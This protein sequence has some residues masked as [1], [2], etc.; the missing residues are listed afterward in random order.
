MRRG[1]STESCRP[2]ARDGFAPLEVVA[3]AYVEI[4]RTPIRI[5]ALR[6]TSWGLVQGA[7]D[8]SVVSVIENDKLVWVPGTT[9]WFR[10]SRMERDSISE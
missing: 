1:T 3:C 4:L 5:G 7:Q 2:V 8:D 6:M 9:T 10:C